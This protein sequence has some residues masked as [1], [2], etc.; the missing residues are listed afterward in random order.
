MAVQVAEQTVMDELKKLVEG[1]IEFIKRMGVKVLTL[2]P[3]RVK[4]MA[5]MKDNENH[6]GTVYAG[7]IFSLGE[8]VGGPLLWSLF[9][10]GK[11]F[12]IVKEMTVR[13]VAPATTDLTVECSI[14]EEIVSKMKTDLDTKGKAQTVLE[15]EILDEQGQLVAVTE[16]IY[17]VRPYGELKSPK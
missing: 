11:Y 15:C 13:F 5:P 4:L 17:Q 16:G 14:P 3:G 1:K 12:P 7:A 9:D 10:P 2:E 8:V 6:I